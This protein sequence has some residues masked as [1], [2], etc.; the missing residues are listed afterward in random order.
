MILL[1]GSVLPSHGKTRQDDI[2]VRALRL[3]LRMMQSPFT[4]ECSIISCALQ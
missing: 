3:I 4:R 2:L 1:A